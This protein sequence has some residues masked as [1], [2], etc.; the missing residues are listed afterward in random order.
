M[1]FNILTAIQN[2]INSPIGELRSFYASRNRANNMGEA[3]ENYVKDVFAGTLN[4]T[5]EQNR[6]ERLGQV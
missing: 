1:S 6:I 2:I 3:L 4:E 5:N